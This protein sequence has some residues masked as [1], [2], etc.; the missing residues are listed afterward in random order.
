MVCTTAK[1][2]T[3][4]QPAD[5][6]VFKPLTTRWKTTVRAWQGKLENWNFMLTNQIFIL[7]SKKYL[8]HKIEE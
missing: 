2:N 4:L 3:H 8:Y 1:H 7:Y 5:V 6:N